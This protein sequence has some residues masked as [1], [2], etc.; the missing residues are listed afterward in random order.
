MPTAPAASPVI[1]M[2]KGGGRWRARVQCVTFDLDDCLWDS[3]LVM[4][5][6]EERRHALLAAEFPRIV[7]KWPSWRDFRGTVMAAVAQD[8]P[9]IAHSPSDVQKAALAKVAASCGYDEALVVE[10]AFAAFAAARRDATLFPGALQLLRS[11]RERGVVV[12]T[13]TNGNAEARLVPGLGELVDFAVTAEQAGAAKPSP[14]IFEMALHEAR[15]A[16]PPGAAITPGTMVHV[17]DDHGKDVLGAQ[18]FGCRSIW[19]PKTQAWDMAGPVAVQ[20]PAEGPYWLGAADARVAEI[21][22][23]LRVIERWDSDAA[24]GGDEAAAENSSARL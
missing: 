1:T 22:G 9:E 16:A 6:A 3:V 10:K 13:I 23:V 21:S 2:K 14:A 18:G 19:T 8:S 7:A 20:L 4:T 17:G 12:G 15:A 5:A 24:V 11:L